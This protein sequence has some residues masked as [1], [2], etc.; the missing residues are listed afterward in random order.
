MTTTTLYRVPSTFAALRDGWT[1]TALNPQAAPA[2]LRD[3][4]AAGI[5]ATV[6]GEATLDLLNAGLIDDPFDG[7]NE[8][9]QQWI[10]DIDWRFTC[11]FT[12]HD[13]G[14]DR[15]DLVAYGLDTIASVSLNGR[16]VGATANFHRSYRWDARGLLRDGENELTVSFASPVRESDR[17][18]QERG[19]YPHTEHHAFN[20]IRKPSYSFGWDWGIDVANAGIWREIGID[21]WSGVRLDEVRPLVD[22]RPDGAGVLT[23]HV[24]VE[25]AGEGRV[26][27]PYDPRRTPAEVPVEIALTGHGESRTA[28]CVVERGRSMGMAVVEVPDAR[29]WW[30]LGYGDQPLY[31][32]AVSAGEGAASWRGRVGFRSV[33]VDTRADEV[34]RP[35]QIYVNDVPVHARGYN[36]IPDDAF[37]TRVSRA[38]YERGMR[39]LV[40]SNSNM[41]RVWGGGIYEADAFYDM[42]DE[43]GVMVWQ[44]F[45]LACAA[46]PEDAETREEVEAEARQA[47]ARLSPHPSLTV[48]NG[49]NENYVAYS[50]W[51]GYKQSLRDDDRAANAY[52][53]GEKPWGDHYYAELFPALLAEL[54][55]THAYLPSSPMSFTQFTAAN[56]DTDGTMH[57]WDAWNRAD[58]RV[59]AEYKPRFADEFGYQAPPAFS[60]LT[61]VVHDKRLDP[62]GEQMLV[63]QKASGGNYKL[64][65]GMR[66]HLTPGNLN[67]VSFGGVVNGD[68]SDGEHSWLI[69]TDDWN[70]IEDWHWACQLQQAQAMRFGVEHMRSLEPV[71]AG[72][73]IWQLNDDWPVVS[74]AAVDFD[75]HRKPVWYASRDFFAPR[76][77]TIQP[78]VSEE[79]RATHSWEGVAVVADHLA[80][81]VL[82]DTREAWSGTWTVERRSLDGA[83]LA[84]E[85]HEV[86]LGAVSHATVALGRDVSTF[87]D[88]RNELVVA[89]ASDGA[90]ARVIHNPAEV[91]DQRL[92]RAA[93]ALRVEA[94][95]A[96]G[97]YRLAVTANA[98]VRDLFCMVDKV[99][100]HASVDG[101]MVSLLP[102]ET[103]EWFVRSDADVE[104]DR[105]AAANVLRC[106]NDLKR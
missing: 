31:D 94:T 98:Y 54:D 1:L 32:V 47:I 103:V 10:G 83:V 57:I 3:R 81:V 53:Y 8:T 6:P 59:Y 46:Y 78:R 72:A 29:L 40:E 75:G 5:P 24:T 70:D 34:G 21:S 33:R 92:T 12:W 71:N 35:F 63:H 51:G 82:N 42:C 50:E 67:D 15:H 106:A 102:G 58:Y 41:V 105:F 44:D 45:M 88:P 66:S 90:F 100:A 77:A 62:F 18:E 73:L 27:T 64:A 13:D 22:V 49:S 2:E 95:A 76:L 60:T 55:P 99:D 36:W 37:I 4:L 20:Q 25:R 9:R 65:R 52:G 69:P 97:G 101:G 39:D 56:L 87:G 23:V 26:M 91:V 28:C 48:W 89:T 17:R 86:S 84:S 74:W 19:Y 104:P 85:T 7:D 61:K 16:P 79:Y 96:D 38:D 30:P 43:L 80:L 11:R 93:E 68:P 14:S